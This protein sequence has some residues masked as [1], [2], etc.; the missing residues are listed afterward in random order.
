MRA[1]TAD[2]SR[3]FAWDFI[4]TIIISFPF[5][6]EFVIKSNGLCG[7]SAYW[8]LLLKYHIAAAS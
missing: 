8:A 2:M 1:M 5:P 6:F 4:M 3:I 7:G